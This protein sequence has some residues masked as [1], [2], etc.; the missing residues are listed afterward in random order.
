MAYD[1]SISYIRAPYGRVTWNDEVL[2][3]FRGREL[4]TGTAVLQ[5]CFGLELTVVGHELILSTEEMVRGDAVLD[6]EEPMNGLGLLA[7]VIGEEKSDAASRKIFVMLVS[8]WIED[9]FGTV[10]QR[11]GVGTL[12]AGDIADGELHRGIRVR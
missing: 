11:V 10:Y 6:C 1:G 12:D 8:P 7:V 4:P 2:S 3:P 5:D 9:G